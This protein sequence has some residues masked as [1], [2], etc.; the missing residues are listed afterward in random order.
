[1]SKSELSSHF[2]TKEVPL[3]GSARGQQ[4][5]L[6]GNH[7]SPAID[8]GQAPHLGIM[9][10]PVQVVERRTGDN[11][12]KMLSTA[13]GTQSALWNG[14][15]CRYW[16]LWSGLGSRKGQASGGRPR[17]QGQALRP[18]ASN[19]SPPIL[20]NTETSTDQDTGSRGIPCPFCSGRREDQKTG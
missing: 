18:Q 2:F 3:R 7:H 14:S 10:Q 1:M 19:P 6:V 9:K 20:A 11:T 13:L 4:C 12:S 17:P 5:G 8:L 15:C 16:R